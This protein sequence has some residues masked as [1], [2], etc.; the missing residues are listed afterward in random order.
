MGILDFFRNP[1]APDPRMQRQGYS[2]SGVGLV[3]RFRRA[4]RFWHPHLAR[5]RKCI[6]TFATRLL[7]S[8]E[9]PRGALL[10]F[11]SGRL[12]DVPWR[13]LFPRFERVV[14]FDADADSKP[15]VE[16]MLQ[17]SRVPNMPKPEFVIG[18][19]TDSVVEVAHAAEQ[20]VNGAG[21]AALA[22][23]A[24]IEG[25]SRVQPP[26]PAWSARYPDAR[27]ALSTNLLSQLGYFP[28]FH[29]Q[30][31]FKARFQQAFENQ[32][33]AV[34]ALECYFNR[35]RAQ[36]VRALAELRAAY[37]SA[38]VAVRSYMLDVAGGPKV[39]EA[40]LPEDAG[41]ALD[42]FGEVKLAWPARIKPGLPPLHTQKLGDLWPE[43][44]DARR[45]DSWAWHIV[46]QGS[47]KNYEES[48]RV[49]V[50]EAWGQARV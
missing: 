49:H 46:P 7:G 35:V 26:R 27:L 43:T 24:L 39:F 15:Q 6:E 42:N 21:S 2:S 11:G 33:H 20:I 4:E 31:V 50:V 1:N 23:R 30:K 25:F 40:P 16:R 28:R 19:L 44:S 36:H 34:E 45:L 41:A 47:E 3:D 32:A 17:E 18:D 37:L 9:T 12:L 14:L 8:D 10:V 22:E 38:D 13:T 5:N 48:G 29:V